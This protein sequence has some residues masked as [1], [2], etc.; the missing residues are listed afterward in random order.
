MVYLFILFFI[1]SQF[2]QK[3]CNLRGWAPGSPKNKETYETMIKIWEG[4]RSKADKDND[5]QVSFCCCIYPGF[6]DPI[7]FSF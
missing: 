4:L 3:I 7:I 2:S 6:F 1:F 5:G